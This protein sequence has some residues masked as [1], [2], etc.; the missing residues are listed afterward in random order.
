MLSFA[1][2][3]MT[4][5]LPTQVAAPARED[6]FRR[7][8]DEHYSFIWRQLRRLGVPEAAVDDAAQEVFVVA[9]RRVADIQPG[10]ERSFLFGVAR[11]VASDAR[12]SK[13]GRAAAVTDSVPRDA[14]HEAPDPEQALQAEQSRAMLHRVLDAMEDDTRE[15]FVLFELEELGRREVADVLGIPEGTAASRLRRAREEFMEIAGRMKSGS[16]RGAP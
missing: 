3:P 4:H 16:R 14:A 13:Q 2:S 15:A 11:R 5:A 9:A 6:S 7:L 1:L 12:R 10:A 8:F